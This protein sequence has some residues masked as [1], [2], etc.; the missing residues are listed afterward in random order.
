MDRLKFAAGLCVLWIAAALCGGCNQVW[1]PESQEVRLGRIVA[2]RIRAKSP[3]SKDTRWLE[4]IRT[5][6]KSIA[7]VSDRPTYGYRFEIVD[8]PDVNAFAVP[9]GSIFMTTG[10]ITTIGLHKQAM[11]GVLAHEIGHVAQRHGAER[12]Q[13]ELGWKGV[14]FLFF[15]WSN[16]LGLA[17]ANFGDQLIENGYGRDMEL[18]ADLCAVRYLLRLGQSPDSTLEFLR[19]LPTERPAS[20]TPFTRYLRTHPATSDRLQYAQQYLKQ[21]HLLP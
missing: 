7:A 14:T 19:R 20:Q 5:L 2:D 9:D 15:G 6:G 12:I 4:Y 3:L 10:L 8:S 17:A 21:N 11:M 16:S 13:S 18:E 1:I